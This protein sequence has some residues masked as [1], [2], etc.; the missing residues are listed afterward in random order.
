MVKKDNPSS[1]RSRTAFTLIELL[2]VIAI[3]AILASIL[4]PVF[5]RAR[6]NARR[7]S[8]QSNM[9]QIGLGLMQYVQDYDEKMPF[10]QYNSTAIAS[11]P[12]FTWSNA[13]FPYT[14]SYQITKCPSESK[15]GY[16]QAASYNV[17]RWPSYGFNY[18]YLNPNGCIGDGAGGLKFTTISLARIQ[19]SSQMVAFA[20]N[21]VYGSDADGYYLSPTVE[22]PAILA[23]SEPDE[24]GYSDGGWG[25]G[26][27][28]DDGTAY[29]GPV[30]G[31][32]DFKARH[33]DGGNVSFVDGHVKWFS[34]GRLASGTNW[35]IGIANTAIDITNMSE[36]L[37]DYR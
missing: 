7:S 22:S 16:S 9:K 5:G 29:A 28:A 20:E 27:Y 32:G 35:R 12:I 2:V 10:Y 37:W 24:C 4:F 6:E 15:P 23:A 13:I 1:N 8:C 21:K 31:T 25:T 36:Y 17:T 3:I 18:N 34:P 19:S 14:K 30:T 11:Q 26:S 33:L